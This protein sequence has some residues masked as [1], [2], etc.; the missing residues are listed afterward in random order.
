MGA[1]EKVRLNVSD[2]WT[3]KDVWEY[4]AWE[5]SKKPLSWHRYEDVWTEVRRFH[6]RMSFLP[7]PVQ[8]R[9][10]DVYDN[11]VD[12][13]G[14][15]TQSTSHEDIAGRGYK[16][17]MNGLE[18]K[19]THRSVKYMT[20]AEREDRAAELAEAREVRIVGEIRGEWELEHVFMCTTCAEPYD[21]LR[22]VLHHK[23]DAHPYCLV[24][25]VT[26]LE[27]VNL[28]P[29]KMIHPQLGRSLKPPS[30]RRQ[31]RAR[32]AN[33]YLEKA[34]AK[35]QQQQPKKLVCTKCQK[36]DFEGSYEIFAGHVL[37]CGGD[38]SLEEQKKSGKKAGKKG[39]KPRQIRTLTAEEREKEL[40]RRKARF[41][42]FAQPPP[43]RLK[44]GSGR[45]TR[46]QITMIQKEEEEELKKKKAPQKKRGRK[47]KKNSSAEVLYAP[48]ADATPPTDIPIQPSRRKR[49]SE[50]GGS[51]TSSPLPA[52]PRR[53]M[54]NY[55]RDRSLREGSWQLRPQQQEQEIQSILKQESE[56]EFELEKKTEEVT[57]AVKVKQEADGHVEEAKL[58]R[59]RRRASCTNTMVETANMTPRKKASRLSLDSKIALKEE[60]HPSPA[61]PRRRSTTTR[62]SPPVNGTIREEEGGQPVGIDRENDEE[63]KKDCL[64]D[65]TKYSSEEISTSPNKVDSAE[66]VDDNVPLIRLKS[67]RKKKSPA[68]PLSSLILNSPAKA[69]KRRRSMHDDA[70]T[71]TTPSNP[72]DSNALVPSPRKRR[73][74]SATSAVATLL[75][76]GADRSI[77]PREVK[78]AAVERISKGESHSAVARD[79]QCPTSTVASWWYRRT[80]LLGKGRAAAAA[81]N[82]LPDVLN[83]S[84]EDSPDSR[85][86]GFSSSS[87]S[88]SSPAPEASTPTDSKDSDDNDKNF[89]LVPYE[90][91]VILEK[92]RQRVAD[93]FQVKEDD[94]EA[95]VKNESEA[96]VAGDV[97]DAVDTPEQSSVDAAAEK[98]CES[99]TSTASAGLS[100]ILDNYGGD[101]D[102]DGDDDE[103]ESADAKAGGGVVVVTAS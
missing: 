5:V 34:K 41:A 9:F 15:A 57:D 76:V 97:V 21:E 44:E 81:A 54:V 11:C 39:G 27:K 89:A 51:G 100:M 49:E 12:S 35:Q 62:R 26:I 70:V 65:N 63:T 59:K 87:S 68:R 48:N 19:Q 3:T 90:R 58:T 45:L 64:G 16:K 103:E 28:P 98:R 30:V 61:S 96:V 73:V 82:A 7:W 13:K 42:R 80:S 60:V 10:K 37:V 77:F 91:N 99:R 75:S 6:E 79:L 74:S 8:Q 20:A 4:G 22:E 78:I 31:R 71:G 92:M 66:A 46:F 53:S 102:I 1:L 43:L 69:I 50:S 88:S 17:L 84:G 24:A 2:P 56:T 18:L 86:N 95:A 32:L 25:H 72:P 83:S 47:P 29:L 67:P 52:R 94:G 14:S 36:A 101:D 85:V 33:G 23:W 93:A 38:S 40:E 55:A